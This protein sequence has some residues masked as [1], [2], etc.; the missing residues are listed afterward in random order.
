[1]E[2]NCPLVSV[3]M[4]CYNAE[5]YIQSTIDSLLQQTFKN[6][7]VIIVND[8]ST[9]Q[10]WSIL[11][12]QPDPRIKIINSE[13]K[14]QCAA[15]NLA[16]SYAK[17]DFIKFMDADDLISDNFLE[18]QVANILSQPNS[19]ASA[20]WGRF[21]GND[22]STFSLNPETV[23]TDMTPI[24]WLCESLK[25]GHNMMQCALWLIPR[26]ILNSSGL[27]NESLS[28]NNDFEF[29]IRVLLCAQQVKFTKGAILYYRSGITTSLSW[30]KSKKAYYSAYNSINLGINH[31]ISFENSE[32]TRHISCDIYKIWSYEFY[33]TQMKLYRFSIHKSKTYGKSNMLYRSGGI[34]KVFS[35]LLGWKLTKRIKILLSSG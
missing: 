16:Y 10:T 19:I 22:M 2:E 8:G 18:L 35:A 32:R 31:L 11:Q 14:G 6:F 4:P 23:W 25:E 9:D 24:D 33:P 15:A 28:L 20:E 12:K 17:G 27:W 5:K 34:T 26:P 7:E 21:Y 3:C 1:M 29:F 13:N 30:Q